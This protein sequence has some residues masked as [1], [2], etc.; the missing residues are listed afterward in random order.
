SVPP[1]AP[2]TFHTFDQF[3]A[4]NNFYGGQLGARAAFDNGRLYV[5]ATGKVALGATVETVGIHGGTLTNALSSS[6]TL[7]AYPG[8]Y[9]SQPTNIGTQSRS[10]FAV[11]PEVD[12]NFGVRVS[13][14]ASFIVG[15]SFLYVSSVARPGDQLDR[16]INPTQ[17]P[18]ITGIAP[19]S[20][21]GMA[22]PM[23]VMRD[24]DFWVQ[25]LNFGLELRY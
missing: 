25:G 20:L 5:N 13:P 3:D 2:D 1:N 14:W 19:G 16:V 10:Q 6:G 21:V 22:R 15:Y 18:A 11:V 7:V 24:T 9:F 23:Q 12:L 8:A 17:A 4:T